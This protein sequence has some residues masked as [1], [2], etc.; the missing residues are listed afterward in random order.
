M[1]HRTRLCFCRDS[2]G[3]AAN[4][5]S[6]LLV[7]TMNTSTAFPLSE[8][9]VTG[10]VQSVHPPGSWDTQPRW[11]STHIFLLWQSEHSCNCGQK[12]LCCLHIRAMQNCSSKQVPAV[13]NISLLNKM[14]EILVWV[15]F[16]SH[17]LFKL[18][19]QFLN[20][21]LNCCFWLWGENNVTLP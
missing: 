15:P 21:Y 5:H 16:G 10:R 3:L 14:W 11:V 7:R 6:G 2:T 20:K 19:L 12:Q 4:I 17:C 13:F 8:A 1:N 9:H 18:D